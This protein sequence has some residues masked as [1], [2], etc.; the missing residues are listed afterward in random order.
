VER[1][2]AVTPAGVLVCTGLLLG[3]ASL[4]AR[5]AEQPRSAEQARPAEHVLVLIVGANS[6][7]QHLDVIDVRKLFLGLTVSSSNLQLRALDN[8][9][10]DRLRQAFLQ[11][12]I[13]MSELAYERRLLAITLQQGARRPEVFKS[14]PDLLDAVAADPGAVSV[15]W[16]ADVAHDHRIRVLRVLWRD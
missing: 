1:R 14:A 7:V 11:N 2:R 10:D 15:A 3:S 5:A 4:P 8:R 12:V 13:A 9:S 6:P 16:I